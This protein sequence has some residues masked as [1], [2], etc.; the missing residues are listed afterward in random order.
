MFEYHWYPSEYLY[1]YTNYEYCFAAETQGGNEIMMGGTL[2]RQHN[3]IF[4]IDNN[5]I[6]IAHAS[7]NFDPH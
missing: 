5:Q 2:L 7:C 1:R 3:L 6:G 4:D